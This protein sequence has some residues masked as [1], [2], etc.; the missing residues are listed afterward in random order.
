MIGGE[1]TIDTTEKQ[2]IYVYDLFSGLYGITNEKLWE[3][4]KG[5]T[6]INVAKI[7]ENITPKQ[8]IEILEK[9]R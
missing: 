2:R 7:L 1:E 6:T 8:V 5:I 4:I 3:I 9:N